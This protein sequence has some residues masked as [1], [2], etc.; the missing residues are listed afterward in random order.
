M[1]SS[2][3]PLHCSSSFSIDA[4]WGSF[5]QGGSGQKVLQDSSGKTPAQI[6]KAGKHTAVP[7]LQCTFCFVVSFSGTCTQL[8]YT[9]RFGM[10][11]GLTKGV[12]E[13][14]QVFEGLTTDF[15]RSG[16]RAGEIAVTILSQ[17]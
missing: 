8:L 9:Y 2:R 11:V 14:A 10:S 1:V 17:G 13:V 4:R 3:V 5:S 7:V 15:S 6:A 16:G 12:Q